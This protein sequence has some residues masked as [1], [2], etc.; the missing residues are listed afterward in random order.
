[1]GKPEKKKEMIFLPAEKI[2]NIIMNLRL[3]R[4]LLAKTKGGFH[5]SVHAE[6][7]F[8]ALPDLYRAW[9]DDEEIEIG[10]NPKYDRMIIA[11][12]FKNGQTFSELK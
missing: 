8:Q 9:V 5:F 12:R 6:F 11:L 10:I 3:G 1:M 2:K 7:L 4:V